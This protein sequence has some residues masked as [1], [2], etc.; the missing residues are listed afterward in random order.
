M[1]LPFFTVSRLPWLPAYWTG[2][3][4]SCSVGGLFYAATENTIETDASERFRNMALT[5]QSA[6]IGRIKTYTD[7]LRG[8]ASLFQTQNELTREQFHNYVDGLNLEQE[9]PGIETINFARHVMD[10]DRAAFEEVQRHDL[11]KVASGYP[12]FAIKPAG[13]RK[14]Y[15]VLTYIEPISAWAH[16]FGTDVQALPAVDASLAESRDTGLPTS[17]GT[18]VT[19]NST[20]VGLGMRMPIYR[21]DLPR[22]TIEERRRAYVGSVGIGFSVQNLVRG[23]LDD[24]PVHDVRLRLVDPEALAVQSKRQPQ[25]LYDNM[26]GAEREGISDRKYFHVALPVEFNRRRWEAHFSI[27]KQNL[28]T[29]FDAYVPWLAMLAGMTSSALLYAL[30][31][32]LASS[33]RRALKLAQDMTFELRSSEN[34][35]QISNENLRRLAA[36]AE[37]IKEGERKRIAREIHDDLGQNLLALRIEADLL[38]SRTS[39]RHHHLHARAKRTLQQIDMTIKSVRQIINDLRPNVLD[40]GLG[41]AVDWQVSQFRQRTGIVCDVMEDLDDM[42]ID[43]GCATALFRILQESLTNISRHAQATRVRVELRLLHAR[44]TMTISDNGVGMDPS[45]RHKPGSFG[46]VG[47]EERVKILGG[48]FTA[49]SRPGAG[50]TIEVSVSAAFSLAVPATIMPVPAPILP[51]VAA[52]V[53]K[54]TRA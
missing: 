18:K 39:E 23:A 15:T 11:A 5:A 1:H 25:V 46:L 36:H 33:R 30:F 24:I 13:R 49:T 38:A 21:A 6:I 41:A 43:D 53:R 2:V 28:Y 45:N 26:S 22:S 12:P 54:L 9:F 51:A 10:G 37:N 27:H 50:T 7:V 14:E 3:V 19:L 32:T 29:G 16:K 34:R 35:L 52:V 47:I 20:T 4:L 44:I 48:T 8:S 42:A 40:L 17:S 31:H